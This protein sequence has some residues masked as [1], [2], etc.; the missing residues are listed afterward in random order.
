MS[1]Q[2]ELIRAAEFVRLGPQE[3][4]DLS[5][6]KAALAAIAAACRKRGVDNAVLDL[7]ALQP[8]PKPVFTTTDLIELVN[9]FPEVGFTKR[10]R[11]AILYRSDP[12]KRARLFAFVSTLHGWQVSAFANFEQALAWLTGCQEAAAPVDEAS[13]GK[14]IRITNP[15]QTRTLSSRPHVRQTSRAEIGQRVARNVSPR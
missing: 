4:F 13:A 12:H 3:E 9:T 14:S 5:A 1:W 6:S 11:L 2:I 8:G 10:L 7:R 15:A